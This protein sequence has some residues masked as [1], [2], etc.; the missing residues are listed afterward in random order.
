MIKKSF[1]FLFNGVKDSGAAHNGTETFWLQ[2]V[3][4]VALIPLVLYFIYLIKFC[5]LQH[6][7]NEIINLFASPVPTILTVL[8]LFFGLY[9]GNLGIKEIIEDYV[10]CSVLRICAIFALN[11]ITIFSGV[12][13]ICSL[14]VLHI[15]GYNL[16]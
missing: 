15:S 2:R 8:F 7:I 13:G 5:I 12:C 10:H 14:V 3:S 16:S 4:A 1:K 9:H 6:D 11:I